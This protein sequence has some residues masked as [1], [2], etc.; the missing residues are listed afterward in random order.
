MPRG[1]SIDGQESLQT[2]SVLQSHNVGMAW[3]KPA[4]ISRAAC[5]LRVED[6]ST[7]SGLY[8]LALRIIRPGKSIVYGC[9][10]RLHYLFNEEAGP[11]L[12]DG[13]YQREECGTYSSPRSRKCVDSVPLRKTKV[14]SGGGIPVSR[15]LVIAAPRPSG[16]P[17]LETI[18]AGLTGGRFFCAGKQPWSS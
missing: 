2:G 1:Q 9:L 14:L 6:I 12:P 10:T 4:G 3:S 8:S 15:F 11:M 18:Q 16:S 7:G 5:N 17:D 13:T